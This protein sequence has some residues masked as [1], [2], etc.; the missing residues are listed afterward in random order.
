MRK[1]GLGLLLGVASL[2]F[3]QTAVNP[4]CSMIQALASNW[5]IITWLVV[6]I[7]GVMILAVGIFNLAAGKAAH[8][9]VVVVGGAVLLVATYRLMNAAGGEL[10]KFSTSCQS[11][12]IEVVKPVAKVE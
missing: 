6:G 8:T 1:L 3:A 4:L 5:G 11:V 12:Q 2:A 7:L 10:N 9:L